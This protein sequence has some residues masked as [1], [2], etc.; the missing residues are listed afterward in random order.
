[1]TRSASHGKRWQ[2]QGVSVH[3]YDRRLPTLVA[4]KTR[5]EAE[6]YQKEHGGQ[7]LNYAEAVQIV[8]E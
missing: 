6:A 4:F 2:P 8:K 1:L 5:A 7:V 3:D